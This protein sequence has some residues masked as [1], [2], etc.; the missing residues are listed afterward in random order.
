MKQHDHQVIPSTLAKNVVCKDNL[1]QDF[2]HNKMIVSCEWP[3]GIQKPDLQ[4]S[5]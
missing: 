4:N 1:Q 5:N 3:K 2:G